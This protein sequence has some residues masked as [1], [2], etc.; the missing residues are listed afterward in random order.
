MP[1]FEPVFHQVGDILIHRPVKKPEHFLQLCLR[2]NCFFGEKIQ[3]VVVGNGPHLIALRPFDPVNQG[4][5]GCGID[6]LGLN[7][8]PLHIGH[9]AYEHAGAAPDELIPL[10]F[11]AG[12]GEILVDDLFI[13]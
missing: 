13:I 12:Q 7:G 9:A 1:S 3:P 10:H 2:G 11:L 5:L 6:R 8:E 4:Q